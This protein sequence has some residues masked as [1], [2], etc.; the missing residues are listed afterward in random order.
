MFRAPVVLSLM[1]IVTGCGFHAVGNKDMSSGDGGLSGGADM[2]QP[3]CATP[4]LLVLLRNANQAAGEL[5]QISLAGA[6]PQ[7]CGMT[8]QTMIASSPSAVA[9]IP[10]DTVAVG[11]D[12]AAYLID[13][14]TDQYRW[15]Q[16][17]A[18][19]VRDLFPIQTPN[20][21]AVAV[22]VL[23]SFTSDI[24]DLLVLDIAHGT[25]KYD[26][27]LNQQPFVLAPSVIDLAQS[28]K[29]PSHVF[30]MKPGTYSADD[31]AV[32]FDGIP[33]IPTDYYAVSAPGPFVNMSAVRTKDGTVRVVW[34]ESSAASDNDPDAVYFT[35]D[36][37][38]GPSLN[39]PIRCSSGT[40]ASPLRFEDA[41]ADPTNNNS[42]IAICDGIGATP[43]TSVVR[44]S[45]SGSCDVLVNGSTLPPLE[46]PVRLALRLN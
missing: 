26:F 30:A 41:V 44:F 40:C 29:D 16:N 10:P 23:D 39:G 34:I 12:S 9:W 21:L 38:A 43:T 15:N 19:R 6:R 14:N 18:S 27:S 24:S 37:G 1:L 33:A 2:S 42:V 31:V 11:A 25:Q 4:T 45:A 7:R 32:P 35:N 8:L 17:V 5:F 28:P 3:P 13:V 36:K 22:A 20:G 46:Y